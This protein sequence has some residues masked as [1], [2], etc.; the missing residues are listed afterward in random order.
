M[1]AFI[2]IFLAYVAGRKLIEPDLRLATVRRF[3]ILVLLDVLPGLYEWRMEQS[4]YG[5]FGQRVL[6]LTKS[7]ARRAAQEWTWK[8]GL[9]FRRRRTR[10]ESHLP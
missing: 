10:R 6:G 9:G 5:M 2:S 3:V 4:L 7:S 8:N 1:T